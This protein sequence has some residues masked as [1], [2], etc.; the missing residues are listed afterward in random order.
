MIKNFLN[1]KDKIT[2]D[3]K[4]KQIRYLE[5]YK[6][7]GFIH[8]IDLGTDDIDAYEYLLKEDYDLFKS[9]LKEDVYENTNIKIT[10]LLEDE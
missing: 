10:E 1:G 7:H 2:L 8:F 3:F 9:C 4:L 6:N 5:D